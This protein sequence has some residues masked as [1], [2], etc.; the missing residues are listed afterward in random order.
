MDLTLTHLSVI[1]ALSGL[2][3]ASIGTIIGT[4]AFIEVKSIQ[5][6]THQIQYMPV[7]DAIDKENEAFLKTVNSDDSWAT[8]PDSIK[9][10][11]TLYKEELESEMPNFV[12]TDEDQEI[13]SF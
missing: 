3:I 5:R 6:S 10:Q 9:K 12:S 4:L 8:S 13:I 2:I 7:D 1:L 11:E